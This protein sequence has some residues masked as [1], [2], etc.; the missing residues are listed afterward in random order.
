MSASS[1]QSFK[2]CPTRFRLAYREG[3][4]V[5]GDT[6]AQRYGN[7]W[8]GMHEAYANAINEIRHDSGGE[9]TP[10]QDQAKE[11]AL[12]A[13]VEYLNKR[14]AE[15][16]NSKTLFE[17]KLERQILLT[18]FLGYLW[19]YQNDPI[20]FL[21]SELPF[22]LPLH[23]PRTGL[24]L[25][26]SEVLRVGKIDHII[27]WQSG[28]GALERK[29]TSR[30][31][32]DDSDY[33]DKAKKDTQVS[34]YALAFR[35]LAQFRDGYNW[36][37]NINIGIERYGNTLYDVWHRPTTQPKDL[38]QDD[39]AEFI[40]TGKY[41]GSD[42]KV[43]VSVTEKTTAPPTY[44]HGVTVDGEVVEVTEG[45]KGFAIRESVEMYG[46]R[47][48]QDMYARPEFYFRRREIART[49]A[50]LKNFRKQLFS[51]YQAMKLASKYEAWI[52]NES[53]CRATFPCPYIAVCYGPGA[54]AVCDGKTTP[55]GYK[56][57]FVDLTVNGE[58]IDE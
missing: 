57:I 28:V 4:R 9:V 19:Y 24:P 17:W 39:T 10:D 33:W 52:E 3:L 21:A 1:I 38:K 26:T 18:S 36:I 22:E 2:A 30:S 5:D 51:T 15:V 44:Q 14:Y 56:R 49:D 6:E 31:I 58:A 25:L 27:K 50:D 42:F 7:A 43:E 37:G 40:K 13:T 47:L 45:K 12:T 35:D 29:S 53:A 48:M 20:E 55:N 54:D 32:S 46:A 11:H 34:M 23:A 8:H 16:P 41:M